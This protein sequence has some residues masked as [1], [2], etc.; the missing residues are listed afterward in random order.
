MITVAFDPE[1]PAGLMS[2]F[3]DSLTEI[4]GDSTNRP[5]DRA[6]DDLVEIGYVSIALAV[7]IRHGRLVDRLI[8]RQHRL[9]WKPSRSRLA[10]REAASSTS[11]LD[12]AVVVDLAFLAL[13]ARS[14]MLETLVR[15]HLV[16]LSVPSEDRS[17]SRRELAEP[18]TNNW[19]SFPSSGP[20][21]FGGLDGPELERTEETR[22]RF[23]TLLDIVD[24]AE[25][26]NNLSAELNALVDPRLPSNWFTPIWAAMRDRLPLLTGDAGLAIEA[27]R[28]GV[29]V[30]DLLDLLADLASRGHID[31]DQLDACTTVLYEMGFTSLDISPGF[32]LDQPMVDG[33]GLRA[34]AT[35][36][37]EPS[38]W[39]EI[40]HALQTLVDIVKPSS[41]LIWG[42]CTTLLWFASDG[43]SKRLTFTGPQSET[44]GFTRMQALGDLYALLH[45]QRT[46]TTGQT[47]EALH[48]FLE[49]CNTD[50]ETDDLLLA[51]AKSMYLTF[52][53]GQSDPVQSVAEA[54][55][56]VDQPARDRIAAILTNFSQN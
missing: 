9:S 28:H 50:D 54:F 18:P 23:A 46:P 25:P 8:G 43:L 16:A 6:I 56:G 22:T 41:G 49:A 36:F 24:V 15:S 42:A 37:K 14:P 40:D 20:M 38:T 34:M 30:F 13:L 4:F 12:R 5:S 11:A 21:T 52:S 2:S 7:E 26:L 1:N 45:F 17:R 35:Q 31:S 55:S 10:S 33:D 3:E 44:D 47:A 27:K 51:V 48:S 19:L 32:L 39:H 29:E 53:A